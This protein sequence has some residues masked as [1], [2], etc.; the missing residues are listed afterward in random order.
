MILYH[1][2]NVTVEK[3]R[4]M[5]QNRFLDFG[6]GFYTTENK[7]QA[8][9]FAEKVYR[10]R[11]TGVQTVS[12]YKFDENAAFSACALLRFDL[13]DEAW[14]DFVFE[15]RTGSYKG[16]LYE[17]IYGPVADDDVY[18]TFVL[19]SVGTYTKEETLKALKVKNLYNQLLF[20]TDR[21]L[22]FLKF[23]GTLGEMEAR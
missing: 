5:P 9:G 21:A 10:R 17:L 15:N 12:V 11:N 6:A 16:R 23:T 19:Y 22:S 7:T 14:L 3:P 20:T 13:P 4:L 1:G 8:I 18:Q 2:S